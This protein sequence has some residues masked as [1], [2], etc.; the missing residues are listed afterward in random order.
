MRLHF[1][2]KN[3]IATFTVLGL[4]SA[5]GGGDDDAGTSAP[6]QGAYAGSLTGSASTEFRM[7][8]LENNEVW[9]L[10]GTPSG[11]S[12]LANGFVQGSGATSGGVFTT[13][14]A[15]DFGFAPG[16]S[17]TATANYTSAGAING[18]LRSATATATFSGSPIPSSVYDYTKAARVTDV[19]GT[20]T[21]NYAG[22][23]NTVTVTSISAT[24]GTVAGSSSGGGTT[25][26]FSGTVA[27]R[28]SGRNVFDVVIDFGAACHPLFANQRT[29]GVAI[30][31][32]IGGGQEQ[33]LVGVVNDPTRTIGAVMSV[34]R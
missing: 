15:K 32:D 10:Y 24:S 2:A 4:L 29:K 7:L 14:N 12:F 17:V 23:A 5:C 28:A 9:T 20:W 11:S 26:T 31:Y 30:A 22:V 34:V 3:L 27:S 19:V 18:S 1:R 8:L 16:V 21:S 6:P 33:L 13:S 25:C